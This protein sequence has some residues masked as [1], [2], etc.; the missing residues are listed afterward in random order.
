M[1]VMEP[2]K[3]KGWRIIPEDADVRL[4]LAAGFSFLFAI[5]IIVSI[6]IP[7]LPGRD[8]KATWE[9]L[10]EMLTVLLPAETSLVGSIVG[11]YFGSRKDEARR[12]TGHSSGDFPS[13]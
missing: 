1:M 2:D 3:G 5:T 7:F 9:V 4:L 10:K 8:P 13:P 6:A 11:F 12:S